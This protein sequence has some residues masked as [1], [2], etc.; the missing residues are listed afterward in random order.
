MMP[1]HPYVGT[2]ARVCHEASRAWC[3]AHGDDSQ[4]SWEHAPVWQKIACADGVRFH[5]SNPHAGPE[6]NHENWF[7][8]KMDAGWIHGPVKDPDADPP[9][10]PCLVPFR[11]L[12]PEQ[13]AKDAIFHAIV[14][15]ILDSLPE[16][17]PH[18]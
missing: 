1:D 10:H 18:G 5:L 15:A 7:R 9:T 17:T 8:H 3:A 4:P 2:I 6:T 16:D 12:A 13:Q 14:H 11:E